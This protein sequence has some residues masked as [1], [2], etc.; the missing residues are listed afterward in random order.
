[1][2][3]DKREIKLRDGE[4]LS[5]YILEN[6]STE[7]II[8]THGLGEHANRHEYF[9]KTLSQKYNICLYDLRGHGESSGKRAYIKSF[10]DFNEDLAEVI[11]YLE[12]TFDM[13]KFNLFGHSLGGLIT[14]SFMQNNVQ[15]DSYPE[16]V[17]L[18]APAT[19]GAGILGGALSCLPAGLM[20]KLGKVKLSLSLKGMLDI[21]KLSHDPRVAA[22]YKNDKKCSQAIPT[23]TFFSILHEAKLVFS[24]PLRV[25]C[26][27][28]CALGTGDEIV[29]SSPTINYFQTI[30][31]NAQ[32]KIIENGYHELHNEVG[33]YRDPYLEFLKISFER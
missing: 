21:S 24:R 2:I 30:E 16:R 23:K 6:G 27:L 8:V 20:G 25:N 32:L 18:S 26:P 4:S 29:A 10:K 14:A 7:W 33:K 28:F 3:S 17:F 31:K 15:A 22:V 13:G 9:F 1:M 5:A 11:S 12:Q 19:G